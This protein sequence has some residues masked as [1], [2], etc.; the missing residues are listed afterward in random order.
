MKFFIDTA[1]LEHIEE[2]LQKGFVSGVTTNP[3]LMS[4]EPKS[5]FTKH[6]SKIVEICKEY[7][8]VPLSVE[9]F[10]EKPDAMYKQAIEI[11]ES[12]NY[13]NLNIKIP[14]GYK[15]LEVVN[16]LSHDNIDVNV[17]CCFTE[18]QLELA[19]LAG[20]RY[21]SLFYNRLLD[22][23]GDPL[24]VLTNVRN[25]FD[26]NNIDSEIIVGSIRMERDIVQSWA[27]GGHIVTAGYNLF[28]G[29]LEHPMTDYSVE[30][31][32]NDFKDWLV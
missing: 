28:P 4:K 23:G 2:T 6:I 5:D 17:T 9:V 27:A 3:S 18:A 13:D 7:G 8:E 16:K 32:L 14:V 26:K 31:F 29:I 20:A 12:L 21:V 19:A 22:Y 11:Y 24:K 25:N 10:A 30:G 15:E 1:N